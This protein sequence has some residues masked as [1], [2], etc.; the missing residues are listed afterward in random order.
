MFHRLAPASKQCITL[1]VTP[2]AT[3]F[4]S[5]ASTAG[6]RIHQRHAQIRLDED[7]ERRREGEQHFIDRHEQILQERYT[8]AGRRRSRSINPPACRTQPPSFAVETK[9]SIRSRSSGPLVR[10]RLFPPR[11]REVQQRGGLALL[12]PV[13]PR[14]ELRLSAVPQT[15]LRRVGA[16]RVSA[17]RAASGTSQALPSRREGMKES[18]GSKAVDRCSV[19]RMKWKRG[20]QGAPQRTERMGS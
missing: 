17:R 12:S 6:R 15:H 7:S 4:W 18:R 1:S 10:C 14:L 9:R 8:C 13:A 20:S 19:A 3:A 2:S 5:C 11:R 16:P